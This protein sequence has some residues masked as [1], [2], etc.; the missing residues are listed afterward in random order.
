MWVLATAF[1]TR[2]GQSKHDDT[3]NLSVNGTEDPSCNKEAELEKRSMREEQDRKYFAEDWR[4]RC[5]M[6]IY[7]T[8]SISMYILE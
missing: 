2:T 5:R 8:D 4:A 6:K 1:F 3:T 7:L